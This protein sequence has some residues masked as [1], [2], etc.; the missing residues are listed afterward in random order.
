[1]ITDQNKTGSCV[2]RT[3][4][5]AVGCLGAVLVTSAACNDATLD[6]FNPDLGLLAHFNL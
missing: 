6:F 3:Q 2:G 5:L 4:R 1:M